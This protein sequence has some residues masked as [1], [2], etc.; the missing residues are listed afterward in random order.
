MEMKAD[1][2]KSFDWIPPTSRGIRQA[3]AFSKRDPLSARRAAAIMKRYRHVDFHIDV[4][5]YHMAK[6]LISRPA[7][8]SI[9][10][11]VPGL[12]MITQVV[13][14]PRHAGEN[15][16]VGGLDLAAISLGI[17][18]LTLSPRLLACPRAALCC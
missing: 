10:V 5:L 4:D 14:P 16:P 1:L 6:A 12:G 3:R 18:A 13:S 8:A 17:S 7:A 15:P 11:D 9:E 2:L